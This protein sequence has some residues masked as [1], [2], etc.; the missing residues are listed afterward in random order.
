[1]NLRDELTVIGKEAV[2][3]WPESA[4]PLAEAI[5]NA[6]RA[7]RGSYIVQVGTHE[8]EL[9]LLS[10]VKAQGLRAEAFSDPSGNRH[11]YVEIIWGHRAA[12]WWVP[13]AYMAPDG[14]FTTLE[15]ER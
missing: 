11:R 5:R 13:H 3:K 1:M 9:L 14:E 6:A 12:R 8:V 10:W 2:T 15:R 7:A 4:T